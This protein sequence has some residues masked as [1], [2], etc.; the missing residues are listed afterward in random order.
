M[1]TGDLIDAGHTDIEIAFDFIKQAVQ[2]AP[3]YFVTGNHEANFS[4][5]DQFKTGLE[6]SGV[7][8][9]EDEAIQLVH[10]N[11]MITLIGLSDSDFTIKGDMFNEAPA[12]VNTK[13]NTETAA[14]VGTAS[15]SR[16]GRTLE[17]RATFFE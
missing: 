14:A 7:T 2:I 6:A 3:V 9:L 5:Y 12:M 15:E 10:N 4:H 1:I 13:L 17:R 8:V 11:E 16:A